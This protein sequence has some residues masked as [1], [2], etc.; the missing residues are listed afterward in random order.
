MQI[1]ILNVA[2]NSISN[3]RSEHG[4]FVFQFYDNLIELIILLSLSFQFK[5]ELV[6]IFGSHG[7]KLPLL[8]YIA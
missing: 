8:D 6:V 4:D 2:D 3:E 1:I 5:E 7:N